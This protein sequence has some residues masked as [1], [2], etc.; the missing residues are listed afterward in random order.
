MK[1]AAPLQITVT[2]SRRLLFIERA[3]YL[4][5]AIAVLV[6]GLSAGLKVVLLAVLGVSWVYA[7]RHSPAQNEVLVLRGDGRL[8]KVGAGDT[9]DALVLH[10]HTTVWPFLVVLLYRK[11]GHLGARVLLGDCFA[12]DDFRQLRCWLRWRAAAAFSK[13]TNPETDAA[14]SPT[15]VAEF[16]GNRD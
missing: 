14:Q 12:G 1:I 9:A 11:N 2:P 8:E 15:H 3:A 4:L 16:P 6:A 10:P 5:A 13:D 7:R